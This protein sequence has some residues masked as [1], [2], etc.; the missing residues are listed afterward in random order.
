M[1]VLFLQDS[2][3][4]ESLALTEVSAVLRAAGHSTLLLLSD[5]EPALDERIREWAPGLCIVP[6]HITGH[7]V[8]LGFARRVKALLPGCVVAMGGTHVTFDPSLALD[9]AVDVTCVGEAEGAFRDLAD[10]LSRG[11]GWEGIPNLHYAQGGA[12]VSNPVRPLIDDLDTLPFPDRALY[13]RY[14]FIARFPWKKFNTSRGCVHS[15]TFCWNTPLRAMYE[16]KGTFTRRKSPARAVAEVA[17]VAARYPLGTVHF[18]DDLFTVYPSWLEEFAERYRRDVGV[19]FTCSSSNELMTPRVARALQRAGCRGVAIGIETGNEELRSRIL[20]KRVTNDDVR[21]AAALVHAHGMEL[22]AFCMIANPGETLDDAFSTIDLLREIRADHVRCNIAVPLPHTE[23]E[24]G[25][26][27]AGLLDAD[28]ERHR[29]DTMKI[30]KPAFRTEDATAFANL[31]YL[32]RP[33]VHFPRLDPLVRRLVH[34]P[35]PQVLDFLRMYIP[36]EEKQIYHIGWV[37]GLRFFSHVGD[38]HKRTA[39]YV[40][41]I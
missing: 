26:I 14:P 20:K 21:A 11:D 25:S 22:T 3:I 28:Y 19:P 5:E 13:Y 39:N 8:A 17:E 12:L 37:D 27:A 24:T 6:C 30:P 23:F 31:F 10:A 4:N 40:T 2:A 18:S 41:L 9:P 29:V 36:W 38:P 33:A 35:T 34:L 7:A 32:F 15:C 1:R 16:G